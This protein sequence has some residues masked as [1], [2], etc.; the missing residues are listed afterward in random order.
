MWAQ[1]LLHK[2]SKCKAILNS[3][4]WETR[5]TNRPHWN[6]FGTPALAPIK[7]RQT[8]NSPLVRS[9]AGLRLRPFKI[10]FVFLKP[11]I[12]QMLNMHIFVQEQ[13]LPV[14]NLCYKMHFPIKFLLVLMVRKLMNIASAPCV[15]SR[16]YIKQWQAEAAIPNRNQ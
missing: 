3:R 5:D 16:S 8:T 7:S 9:T 1:D 11:W 2:K 4:Q 10:N 6:G 15:P 14:G 13:I 12:N